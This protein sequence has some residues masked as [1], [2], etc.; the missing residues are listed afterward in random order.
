M[1]RGLTLDDLLDPPLELRR[2]EGLAEGSPQFR[3]LLLRGQLPHEN[4]HYLYGRLLAERQYQ[5]ANGTNAKSQEKC[6]RRR[7]TMTETIVIDDRWF[8]NMCKVEMHI[9][10]DATLLLKCFC[11]VYNMP[12]NNSQFSL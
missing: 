11:L 9:I 3:H 10:N 6:Y 5:E 4:R 12:I 2:D 7:Q 1:V 8:K